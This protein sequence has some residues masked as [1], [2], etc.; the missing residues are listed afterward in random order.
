MG[1]GSGPY[2]KCFWTLWSSR[3]HM[4][5]FTR[6][7]EW[8]QQRRQHGQSGGYITGRLYNCSLDDTHGDVDFE[9]SHP[10]ERTP[11][12]K[13]TSSSLHKMDHEL[14]PWAWK[15]HSAYYARYSD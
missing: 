1:L 15:A 11:T 2:S 3:V 10:E 8:D 14:A 9:G 12:F 4:F 13:P 5:T 6:G 7:E